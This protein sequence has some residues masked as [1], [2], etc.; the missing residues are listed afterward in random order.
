MNVDR[1]RREDALRVVTP[2]WTHR[3][4]TARRVRQRIR[5]VLRWAWANDYVTGNVAGEGRDGALST[6]PAVKQHFR[7]LP[8]GKVSEALERVEATGASLAAAGSAGT[9]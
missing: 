4:E 5:A 9:S 3:P 1:I 8:Y 7:P 6:M 2:I